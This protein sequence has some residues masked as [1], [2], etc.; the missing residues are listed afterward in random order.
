[1]QENNYHPE[2]NEVIVA[3]NG[4]IT[5]DLADYIEIAGY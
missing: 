4:L 5:E 1:M 3:E 2:T